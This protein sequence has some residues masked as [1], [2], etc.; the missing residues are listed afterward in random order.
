[1]ATQRDTPFLQI[2]ARRF[3]KPSQM[4][5]LFIDPDQVN[6]RRLANTLRPPFTATVVATAE[7]AGAALQAKRPTI[8]VT[9]LDLP[10]MSGL[11]LLTSL[12]SDPTTRRVLLMVLTSRV[13][14]QDKIAA[15]QAGADDYLVKP[16][17]P[18]QLQVHL[19]RLSLFRQTFGPTGS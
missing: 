13:A 11:N 4:H 18:Q 6:V 19:E 14:L 16:V 1:M 17:D 9:E 5:V 12:H 7:A 10:G 2:L 3:S 15:F 8:I